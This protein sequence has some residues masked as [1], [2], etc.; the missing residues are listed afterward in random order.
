V[1]LPQG[2]PEILSHE[3]CLFC[4]E[5]VN[6][7]RRSNVGVESFIYVMY[8]FGND[9]LLHDIQNR[10]PLIKLKLTGHLCNLRLLIGLSCYLRLRSKQTQIILS[11]FLM[12]LK[13]ISR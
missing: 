4:S 7:D 3:Q 1:L 8:F 2:V 5:E 6:V 9:S 12:H 10:I 13:S 11:P